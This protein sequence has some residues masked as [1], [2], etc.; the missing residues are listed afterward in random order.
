MVIYSPCLFATSIQE[1]SS[2]LKKP[3]NSYS[4]LTLSGN[5]PSY[6]YILE[7]GNVLYDI[8]HDEQSEG[9]DSSNINTG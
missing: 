2:L 8:I 4:R 6:T 5:N 1:Y 3:S 9:I 7:S